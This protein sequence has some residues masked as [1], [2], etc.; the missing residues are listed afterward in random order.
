[1][2]GSRKSL[3]SSGGLAPTPQRPSLTW[4][5]SLLAGLAILHGATETGA[6]TAA[7]T[8]AD[9]SEAVISCP[10]TWTVCASSSTPDPCFEEAPADST[11]KYRYCTHGLDW[12]CNYY[13]TGDCW[14]SS[15]PCAEAD[16]PAPPDD[17]KPGP[18]IGFSTTE[19]CGY[20]DDCV[21]LN[22]TEPYRYCTRYENDDGDVFLLCSCSS[23]PCPEAGQEPAT[24]V[25]TPAVGTPTAHRLGPSYPN[26]FNPRMVIPL[27]LAA[28][29]ERVHLALYN[30]LGHQVRQLWDGPLPAGSHRFV[31]DG[32]GKGKA[33]AAG[34]YVY[35]LEVGGQTIVRKTIKIR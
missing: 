21:E 2:N 16:M 30:A 3:G 25:Q 17:P 6:D 19:E 12:K 13:V 1:M 34:V 9:T 35:K 10:S 24:G 31:W 28:D 29:E 20:F 27:H 33:L 23:I 18:C 7:E 32:R 11:E 22:A 14:Y 8:E 15:T 5:A 26:P 4:I